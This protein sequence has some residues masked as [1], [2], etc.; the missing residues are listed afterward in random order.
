MEI[1]ERAEKIIPRSARVSFGRSSISMTYDGDI[2]SASIEP[3]E[4]REVAEPIPLRTTAL[5]YFIFLM[6]DVFPDPFILSAERF[7]ISLFYR[8]LDFRKNQLVDMLQKLG[9]EGNQRSV[10][11]FLVID[12]TTSR[13]A[14]PIKDNIDFTRSIPDLPKDLSALA[15]HKLFDEIKNLIGGYYGNATED[16]RFHFQ[17]ARQGPKLQHSAPPRFVVGKRAI[18]S[19]LL[20]PSCSGGGPDVDH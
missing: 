3:A 12:R 4:R 5:T 7:G 6:H 17:G 13:Y 11:P 19:L 8:E 1:D 16:I 14:L 18:R 9:D 2:L 20:P 10:S 15:D